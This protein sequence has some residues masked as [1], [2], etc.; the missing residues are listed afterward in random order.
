MKFLKKK[1]EWG[2]KSWEG[3][4]AEENQN[5]KLDGYSKYFEA[6]TFDCANLSKTQMETPIPSDIFSPRR[7]CECVIF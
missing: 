6:T 3:I 2:V 5:I 7:E 1:W 4:Y